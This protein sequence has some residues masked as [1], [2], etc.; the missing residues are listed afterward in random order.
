MKIG[1]KVTFR[2]AAFENCMADAMG[3]PVEVEGRIVGFHRSHR[4]YRAEY[5]INATVQHEC[6][7]LP[8]AEDLDLPRRAFH[9]EDS[10]IMR[11]KKG[12]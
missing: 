4:W 3:Y 11:G 7:F 8:Q 12:E 9:R 5:L 1:D 10:Q 2:P 6:F